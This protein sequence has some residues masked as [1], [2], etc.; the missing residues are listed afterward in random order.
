MRDYAVCKNGVLAPGKRRNVIIVA[1]LG[2]VVAIPL[3]VMAAMGVFS[4][5]SASP[6]A[7]GTS[8]GNSSGTDEDVRPD[9]MLCVLHA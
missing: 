2:V 7:V 8:N 1:M 3:I 9:T 6:S 4:K 5:H